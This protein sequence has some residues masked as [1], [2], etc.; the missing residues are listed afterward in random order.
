MIVSLM[1]PAILTISFLFVSPVSANPDFENVVVRGFET[2][3]NYNGDAAAGGPGPWKLYGPDKP[4]Q[5]PPIMA[6]K[7]I[8]G[9]GA[10]VAAGFAA[11]CRDT[12]W[13]DPLIEDA[14]LDVLLDNT[15]QWMVPGAT[16]V[17]WYGETTEAGVGI[18]F[19]VFNDAT[20]C[21]ELIS[22]LRDKGYTVDNTVNDTFDNITPDLLALNGD[23]YDILV[24]PQMQRGAKATGGNPD[25][26]PNGV[27]ETIYDFVKAG[28]GLLIMDG[29]DSFGY[30]YC[31]VQNKILKRFEM[32]IYF[33]SDTIEDTQ[34]HWAGDIFRIYAEVD[35]T[36]WIGSAYENA[37]GTKT[38]GL[39]INCTLAERRD[40]E[41]TVD[42]SPGYKAA[43]PGT[44]VT[45]T[46]SVSSPGWVIPDNINLSVS[47]NEW[48]ATFPNDLTTIKIENVGRD[49]KRTTLT[50]TIP[51]GA[52]FGAEDEITVTATSQGDDTVSLDAKCKPTAS[53]RIGPPVEDSYTTQWPQ[54]AGEPLGSYIWMQ[55]GSDKDNNKRSYLKFDLSALNPEKVPPAGTLTID[56]IHARLFVHCARISYYSSVGEN[57]QCFAVDNDDWHENEMWWE[58]NEPA[59]VG[60]ALDTTKIFEGD[61]EFAEDKKANWYSWDV[62]SYVI[63][64]FKTDPDNIASF[65]LKAEN[66]NLEYPDTFY[67]YS[68]DTSNVGESWK[69]PYLVI[70]YD[71]S[72]SISPDYD[73]QPGGTL[74]YDINVRNR[75][76]FADSYTLYL[77]NLW[78]ATLSPD[79]R[80]VNL[81]PMET[82]TR[83]LTVEIPA[84]AAIGDNVIILVTAVS[85]GY[86]GENDNG[87]CIA[88]ASS[89]VSAWED[90]SS[91]GRDDQPHHLENSLWGR[92]GTIYVGH[93]RDGP[94]R[95][96][97]KFDLRA[98]QAG[99]IITRANLN[100]HCHSTY[101]ANV[102]VYGVGDDS[103]SE[104]TINWL[105]KPSIAIDNALDNRAVIENYKWYSWDVTGFVENQYDGD[106]IVS[107]CMVDIGENVAPDHSANFSSKEYDESEENMPY[108]EI[109]ATVPENEV[110][111]YV[112]PIFQGGLIE[113]TLTYTITVMNK[114]TLDDNYD[115]TVENTRTWSWTLENDNLEVPAGKNRTTWLNV[116]IP[117]DGFG[118]IND[119]TITAT[120]RENSEVYDNIRCLAHRSK[121]T[122]GL[123]TLYE[124]RLNLNA[125]LREDSSELVLKFCT[126]VGALQ[127]NKVVWSTMPAHLENVIDISHPLHK[128]VERAELVLTDAEGTEIW[129]PRILIVGRRALMDRVFGISMEYPSAFPEGRRKLMDEVFDISMMYPSAPP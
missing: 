35:N 32:G 68:F 109:L 69:H 125:L 71:V 62:T 37:T 27:V 51:S 102:R 52:A 4:E 90:S 128:G 41:V 113:D 107:F 22:A 74:T 79:N 39:Y 97:L 111:A 78:E 80:I 20:R 66:E 24:L 103:W 49:P 19:D 112:N 43:F 67:Y 116:T 122:L 87:T 99:T 101:G 53:M 60:D 76:T 91:K 96:W 106:K 57:V 15:F 48:P 8:D 31:W 21:S 50:V 44:A 14:H 38:I 83:T 56:D 40:R 12:R 59:T 55:V 118:T 88:R 63:E 92:A 84:G 94:E 3:Y 54:E 77:E 23:N 33:Q 9:G 29:Y 108:L 124:V 65:C 5:R 110:R 17:L 100:L 70:G 16:T 114:G 61:Y 98:F 2:A 42:I 127:D 86:P 6:T 72:T 13:N 45:Y 104:Y 121:A 81:G 11:T 105:N 47:D 34:N 126:W 28:G 119:I 7:R 75:G 26:L 30:N 73:G 123:K 46:V 1:A 93:Y 36:T 129:T 64:Q 10:V 25:E 82:E 58:E 18:D 85:D 89:H 115:L 117:S 120:S 95:G